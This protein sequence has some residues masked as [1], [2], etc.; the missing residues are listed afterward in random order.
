MITLMDVVAAIEGPE[1][2]FRCTEIRQ[3]GGRRGDA[4]TQL[5]HPCAIATAMRT[6]ELAWR[7]ALAAQTLPGVQVAVDRHAPQAGERTRR[8]YARN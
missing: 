2:A 6:A 4:G 3:R 5:P 7:R 1:D 8:W